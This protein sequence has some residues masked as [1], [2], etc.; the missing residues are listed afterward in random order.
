MRRRG[1]GTL[2]RGPTPNLARVKLEATLREIP[3]S[4]DRVAFARVEEPR[5]ARTVSLDELPSDLQRTLR[6]AHISS[7]W[8]HQAQA[9]VALREGRSV[10]ISTG[11]ASGKSLVYQLALA[12]AIHT[13]K[14]ATTL[15]VFPTKAL[16]Q[17]QLGRL[18][19][20][21]LPGVS[22]GVYDGDTSQEH[23][24]WIRKQANVVLTN[25]D[26]LHAAILGGHSRWAGFLRNLSL[27]VV[28]EAHVYRG[29]FGAQ[30]S[31]VLRRLRR[32]AALRGTSPRFVLSSATI[33]NPGEHAKTLTGL[34]CEVVSKDGGPSSRRLVVGWEPP[35][36]DGPEPSR[37]SAIA[38]SAD[39]LAHLVGA[40]SATLAFTRSRRAAEVVA[41]A[42]AENLADP[43]SVAAY[44]AGY[45]PEER[46]ELE[47]RLL[48]GE[49]R[50]V[51]ATTALELGIDVGGL[52]AV[53]LSGFPG[54]R[55]AFRQQLGRAGRSNKDSLG[56]FVLDDNPLDRYLGQHPDVL[57]DDPPEAVLADPSNPIIMAEHLACAAHESPLK[58]E[59]EAWFGDRFIDASRVAVLDGTLASKDGVLRYS[60]KGEPHRIHGLRSSGER[61]QIVDS[62]TGAL[63]GEASRTQ[64]MSALHT[65]AMYLHQRRSYEVV[66]LDLDAGV[67]TVKLN[68]AP[69]YTIARGINDVDV[70]AASESRRI[71]DA[72]LHLG[73][74]VVTHQVVSYAR[75]RIGTGE[76]LEEKPLDL[77]EQ[78]MRT[79]GTWITV[80]DA[81]M[82][83]AAI[84]PIAIG[85]ALHAAE[86]AM[87]GLLPLIVACDHWDVGGISTPMHRSTGAATIVIYDGV[88]GGAGFAEAVYRNAER[89]IDATLDR[90]RSCP[91]LKGC[92]SCVQS[93]QCGNGNEPLDKDAAARL[94]ATLR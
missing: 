3:G 43:A 4:A 67:A 66:S 29:V 89:L 34:D 17:D 52:D 58:R 49:L 92:P 79:I 32:L 71:G 9:L 30:V 2:S 24:T 82:G 6:E 70:I 5:K 16:T 8:S 31:L 59:D 90:L 33:G 63:L 75:R 50:G 23:R 85:G 91:C 64:A 53:I 27:V 47:R 7:L 57:L 65:G 19:S 28:D 76:L 81:A 93:P 46:R 55:A 14:H 77:P 21:N 13:S 54:T 94:L 88:E 42:A 1:P 80:D 44:R 20:L 41:Q 78:M 83:A 51:A 40:G 87:I 73:P 39:L 62:L 12:E 18:H 84:G 11:T 60:G 35:M 38:E 45:L 22:A 74:V 37:R 72:P 56:I 86:H 25:P 61:V 68:D 48:S 15:M 69:W 10:T 26:M 36:E